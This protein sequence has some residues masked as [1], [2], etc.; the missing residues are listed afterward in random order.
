MALPKSPA[1][2]AILGFLFGPLGLL[3]ASG[4]AALIMFGVNVAVAIFTL[5]FGLFLTWP[6]SAIVGYVAATNYNQ[7]LA[8]APVVGVSRLG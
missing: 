6:V 4:K 7:R 2:A 5:G 1:V 3:Y 8:G